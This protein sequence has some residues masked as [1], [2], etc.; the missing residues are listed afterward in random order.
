VAPRLGQTREHI[1]DTAYQLFYEH[2]FVRAS[3]DAIAARAGVT[4]RTLY[5]HFDSKDRLLAEVLD[6]Q[7]GMALRRIEEWASR[8]EGDAA[9][10]VEGY[11]G[12]IALWSSRKRWEGPGYTRLVMELADLPGHP[13]RAVASRHKAA[14][15]SHLVA[16]FARRGEP[17]R[18]GELARILAVL[19][20]GAMA[21]TLVH[22]GTGYIAAAAQAMRM[23]LSA[24]APPPPARVS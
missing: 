15:E 6:H 19:A 21:L 14:V 12:E 2:G 18:A 23:I 20:E 7:S 3:L 9:G 13:A 1:L 8:L 5:Y 24:G 16:E 4:K 10:F 17:Q 11:F 22:G